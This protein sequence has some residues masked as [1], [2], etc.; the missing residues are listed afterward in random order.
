LAGKPSIVVANISE[1]QHWGRE[2]QRIGVAARP[3]DRR[4]VTARSIAAQIKLV[5]NTPQMTDKAR[6][7]AK[8]MGKENGVAEAVSL[9]ERRFGQ[10]RPG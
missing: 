3:L 9:I 7:I 4:S 2:L 6:D 5:Q 8:A 10:P 1:Q